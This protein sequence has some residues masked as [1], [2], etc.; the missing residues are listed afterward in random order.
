[1]FPLLL[2]FHLSGTRASVRA[3]RHRCCGDPVPS[4]PDSP[5]ETDRCMSHVLAEVMASPWTSLSRA[6]ICSRGHVTIPPEYYHL[7]CRSGLVNGSWL[8]PEVPAASTS[9]VSYALR[10]VFPSPWYN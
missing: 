10:S 2:F 9:K 3:Q 4:I 7:F 1:M 5:T 8:F 6:G